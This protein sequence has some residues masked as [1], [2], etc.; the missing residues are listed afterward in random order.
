M[1]GNRNERLG[2]LCNGVFIRHAGDVIA[3]NT[4]HAVKIELRQEVFRKFLRILRIVFIQALKHFARLGFFALNNRIPIDPRKHKFAQLLHRAGNAIMHMRLA[5][6]RCCG[7]HILNQRIDAAAVAF[8]EHGGNAVRYIAF[9]KHLRAHGIVNIMVEIGD[10]VGIAN[11]LPLQRFRQLVAR[12]AEDAAPRFIAEIQPHAVVFQLVHNA[13]RL[14]VMAKRFSRDL[15]ER[16]LA[17]MTERRM[18]QIMSECNRL[19]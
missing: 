9:R 1:P 13:K 2:V 12:M 5:R 18:P 10:A 14:L 17:G 8:A 7:N 11:D 3:Y 6:F 16:D 19:G 15:R 4:L